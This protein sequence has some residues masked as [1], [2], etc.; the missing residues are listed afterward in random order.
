MCVHMCIINLQASDGEYI[1]LGFT[2]YLL[3][4]MNVS[5]CLSPI[6]S[7]NKAQLLYLK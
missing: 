7:F 1:Y 3:L 2:Y 5:F 6:L 4:T